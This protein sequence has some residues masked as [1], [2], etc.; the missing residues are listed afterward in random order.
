MA[1][2]LLQILQSP[3]AFGLRDRLPLDCRYLFV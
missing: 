3:E 2:D 1:L